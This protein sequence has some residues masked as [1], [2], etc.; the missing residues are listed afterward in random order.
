MRYH[1][2]ALTLVCAV[3]VLALGVRIAHSQENASSSTAQVSM[4]ITDQALND[5]DEMTVLRAENVQVRQGRT[6]LKVNQLIPATGSN[7]AS[8][9][10]I[11][12]DETTYPQG[13]GNN[14]NELRDFINAQPP[15]TAVGVAYMSN[16]TVQIAQNLTNDHALAVKAIRLPRGTLSAMDSPY[17]SLISLVNSWPQQKVRR[18]V[19]IFTDGIDRLRGER[20][21]P[22]PTRSRGGLGPGVTPT[23]SRGAGAATRVPAPGS[24]AL[25]S[26]PMGTMPTISI[27]TERTSNLCQRFG[28]IV[29]GIYVTGVGR[30]G[31]NAWEVQLG[32]A[33]IGRIADETGGEYFSLGTREPI[34]FRPFLDRLQRIFDNQYFLVFEATPRRN[35]GLQRVNISTDLPNFEISAANNVWVPAAER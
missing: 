29:H 25:T 13:V 31:R 28:V 6:P 23:P 26:T 15:S 19:L 30:L 17:L 32:Q 21:V 8:Q 7:A 33:G 22:T 34:S 9:V 14:L 11:L 1:R 24:T 4:V 10:F 18:Q 27:D 2:I 16:A 20:N 3:C 12:I 35:E 5:T